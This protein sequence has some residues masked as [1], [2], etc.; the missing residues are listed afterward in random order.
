[1][2]VC[3]DTIPSLLECHCQICVEILIEP[4]TLPCNH[5]LCEA[6]FKSTVEKTNLC[7]SS[8]HCQIAFWTQY[9]TQRNSLHYPEECKLRVSGQQSEEIMRSQSGRRKQSQ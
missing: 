4:V 2:A 1:M 7:C 5:T 8:C 9:H 6:C 3:K